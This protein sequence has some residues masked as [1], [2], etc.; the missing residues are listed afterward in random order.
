MQRVPIPSHGTLIVDGKLFEANTKGQT[1]RAAT[2]PASDSEAGVFL[3]Q[4]SFE[5]V[6]QYPLAPVGPKYCYV[7]PWNACRVCGTF[8]E[9]EVCPPKEDDSASDPT[10][11]NPDNPPVVPVPPDI[12]QPEKFPNDN[13]ELPVPPPIA[14]ISKKA[15]W[16]VLKQDRSDLDVCLDISV[17]EGVTKVSQQL[18][19][20]SSESQKW[21]TDL[22][23]K[24]VYN[25]KLGA[26]MCL[27]KD[28][29]NKRII[30]S[31]CS[32]QS[33]QNR[34]Q[35]WYFSRGWIKRV[36]WAALINYRERNWEWVGDLKENSFGRYPI[37]PKYVDCQLIE[38]SL[39]YDLTTGELETKIPFYTY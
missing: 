22:A 31:P 3:I 12:P 23:S 16:F 21:G 7:V 8:V 28:I 25:K 38:G 30:M 29:N 15:E 32:S 1:I 20:P 13:P 14:T 34:N 39:C 17:E 36:P 5:W 37:L 4:G 19:A 26:D 6:K 35:W 10:T 27:T 24:V 2:V 11:P 18:C 9:E 33:E